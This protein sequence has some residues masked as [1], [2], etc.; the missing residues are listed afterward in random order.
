MIFNQHMVTVKLKLNRANGILAKIR[1]DV[2][3]Q[4]LKTIYSAIFESHLQYSCQ[5]WGRT[6]TQVLIKFETKHSEYSTL[7]AHANP[8]L[9]CTKNKKFQIIGHCNS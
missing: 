9:F 3:V 2:D 6:Q 4:L 5:L 7:K 8:V 1:Y